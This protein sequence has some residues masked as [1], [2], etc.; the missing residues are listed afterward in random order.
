MAGGVESVENA[1]QLDGGGVYTGRLVDNKRDGRG[2]L[3]WQEPD[4]QH[5]Y[6]GDWRDGQRHGRGSHTRPGRTTY[7]GEWR[8]GGRDGWGAAHR[9]DGGTFEGLW[10]GDHWRRGAWHSPN[11]VDVKEGE[12]AWDEGA[13]GYRMEGWGL[14]RKRV[15]RGADGRLTEAKG[16]GGAGGGGGGCQEEGDTVLMVTVYEGEWHNNERHGH[17]MWRS[18]ET[19]TIYC[20]EWDHDVMTGTGRM[21]IGDYSTLHHDPG[22]SYVG[23][24]G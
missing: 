23:I 1:K 13:D 14:W 20:G 7:S 19:G 5:T 2:K 21:L 18:P 16:P 3:T 22:G 12:W 9:A 24:L 11:G 15:I 17:G 6:D 4:G 10:R 8:S